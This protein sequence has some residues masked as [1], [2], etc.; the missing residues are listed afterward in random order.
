MIWGRER[1]C[2]Y[3]NTFRAQWPRQPGQPAACVV[4]Y[5]AG[6]PQGNGPA[7]AIRVSSW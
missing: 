7:P 1:H 6:P 3:H 4:N 2:C 5:A